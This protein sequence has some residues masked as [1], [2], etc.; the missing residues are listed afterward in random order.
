MAD[1]ITG[2][3]EMAGIAHRHGLRTQLLM[4]TDPAAMQQLSP[5]TGAEVVV[6]AT[7]TRSGTAAE[8]IHT[9]AAVAELLKRWACE[10]SGPAGETAHMA[11]AASATVA[12]WAVFKKTDSALRGHIAA[13]TTALMA[14]L[15]YRRALLMAQNPSRGRVIAADGQYYVGGVPLAQTAFR[16]DPE[17]PANTSCA[18]DLVRSR[19]ADTPDTLCIASATSVDEVARQVEQTDALTLVA[20]AADCFEAFLRKVS[21]TRSTAPLHDAPH[22]GGSPMPSRATGEPNAPADKPRAPKE[23]CLKPAAPATGNPCQQA[24]GTA[25][26]TLAPTVSPAGCGAWLIVCGSTQGRSLA[27]E[28]FIRRIGAE[29]VGMTAEVFHGGEAEPWMAGLVQ[30]YRA[31]GSVVLTVGHPSTGGRAYAIRLRSLMAEAV[32]RLIACRWPD[33]IV[34]E[35]GATAFALL[36]RLGWHTFQVSAELA[37]GIVSM[38]YTPPADCAHRLADPAQTAAPT[39]CTPSVHTLGPVR[40]ILKPGSYPWGDLFASPNGLMGLA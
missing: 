30:S 39:A 12:P 35:G 26:Q 3:A 5:Q 21:R 16:Y 23:S 15:G 32:D 22:P 25:L 24:S 9:T 40:L 36:G 33:H 31:N 27:G 20:G 1:D 29:E 10:A 28:P 4:W 38:T 34:I 19:H 8:A 17:F 14:A 11:G 6:I 2:A 7:D 18:H 37:P 13:E